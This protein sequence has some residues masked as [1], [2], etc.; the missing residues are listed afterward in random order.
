MPMYALCEAL[1]LMRLIQYTETDVND[2]SMSFHF[3][4]FYFFSIYLSAV[5]LNQWFGA[6]MQS[7][8]LLPFAAK[9]PNYSN[10]LILLHVQ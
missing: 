1:H 5:M 3:S 7:F 2:H 6:L 4:N 9:V 10:M 8:H